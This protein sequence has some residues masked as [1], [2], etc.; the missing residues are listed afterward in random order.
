MIIDSPQFTDLPHLRKLWMQAFGDSDAFWLD[1][2]QKAKPLHRCRCI[3]EGNTLAAALYW[4]DCTWDGKP[5]AY[6]YGVATGAEFRNRGLCRALMENTHT[7]LKERGYHG[8]IL[9]PG[10]RELFRMYEKLG[11]ATCSRIHEFTA[12]AGTPI[13]LRAIDAEEYA[14]RRREL[15][16]AGGVV[17]EGETL[18]FLASQAS[19]YAGENCLLVCAPNGE[20]LMVSELLPD[21]EAAPGIL[22]TL[23]YSQ[24]TFRTPG[25]GKPFAMYHALTDDSAAPAYFGLAMD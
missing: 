16:P 14:L 20:E 2:L 1:F 19:F 5:L 23:G 3:W 11:Y 12:A 10:S 18:P 15:L 8:C 22:A 4:F 24:G 21:A 17:Q 6:L 7:L 9:V 13:P 25:S